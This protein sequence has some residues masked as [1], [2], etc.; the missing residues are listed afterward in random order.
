MIILRLYGGLGNQIFQI[1]AAILLAQS[2]NIDNITIDDSSLNSY[3][4]ERQ[5]DLKNFFD[6]SL[7]PIDLKFSPNPITKLRLPKLLP[8]KLRYWPLIGD[9]NFQ[10]ALHSG[11]SPILLLDGYFQQCLRQE[12]FE[13][14]NKL[15]S[16]MCTL[17]L[18]DDNSDQC[19]IH[20]RGGDFLRLGWDSVTSIDFYQTAIKY[21]LEKYHIKEFLVVTDDSDYA[22]QVMS[23]LSILCPYRLCEGD[24]LSDFRIIASIKKRIISNSTFA[25]WASAFGNNDDSV[26]IAPKLF[27]ADSIRPFRLKGEV[28]LI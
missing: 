14:I 24:I 3:E 15:L 26:V 9:R 25:L 18:S 5:N 20:I 22:L 16:Q 21:M 4:A 17:K 23:S 12:D 19:V 11:L 10:N 6:F 27:K 2:L 28:E 8:L 7:S 13:K 1:G